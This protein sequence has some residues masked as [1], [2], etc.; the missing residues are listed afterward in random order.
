M[1]RA[2]KEVETTSSSQHSPHSH[3]LTRGGTFIPIYLQIGDRLDA[4]LFLGVVLY[5]KKDFFF[6]NFK[7]EFLPPY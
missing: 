1:E 3:T 4:Q 7:T 2:A 6:F 5:D